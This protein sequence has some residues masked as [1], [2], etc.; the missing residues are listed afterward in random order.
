MLFFMLI[1][2]TVIA[3]PMVIFA[4]TATAIIVATI[5]FMKLNDLQPLRPVLKETQK[6]SY[7]RLGKGN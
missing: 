5:N 4:K 2:D 7:Q 3:L 6:L 1:T